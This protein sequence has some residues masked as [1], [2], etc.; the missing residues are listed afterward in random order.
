MKKPKSKGRDSI[1][2]KPMSALGCGF[3]PEETFLQTRESLRLKSR[4][5]RRPLVPTPTG[6]GCPPLK[7]RFICIGAHPIQQ[8]HIGIQP[9][10]PRLQLQSHLVFGVSI[11]YI[12]L[13]GAFFAHSRLLVFWLVLLFQWLVTKD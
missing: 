9:V 6:R 2:L 5:D 3:N 12:A 10:G 13:D 11:K 8:I 7:R 1:L 4:S